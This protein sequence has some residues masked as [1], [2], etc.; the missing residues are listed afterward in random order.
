VKLPPYLFRRCWYKQNFAPALGCFRDLMHEKVQDLQSNKH[1][2]EML[3]GGSSG[4][5]WK[6]KGDRAV[7]GAC[8]GTWERTVRG[9]LILRNSLWVLCDYTG[10]S[11][12][13]FPSL[14]THAY[15]LLMRPRHTCR[16]FELVPQQPV[17]PALAEAVMI[18]ST[19]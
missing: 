8:A 13:M 12:L 18:A 2:V 14:Q 4:A 6:G 1:H 11:L 10:S 3:W 17:T 7:A 5:G 9:V 19:S 16:Q 15:N